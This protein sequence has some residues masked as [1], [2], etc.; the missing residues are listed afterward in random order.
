M[1]VAIVS[2][3]P[4][5]THGWGRYTRDLI[6]GLA[7]QPAAPQVI[8]ITARDAAPT[9]DLPVAEYHRVLPSLTPARRFSMLRLL[10]SIPAVSRL[11]AGCDVVHVIAEPY[12]L[13]VP[14]AR[15]VIMTAHGTY[16]AR[17]A[18]HRLVGVL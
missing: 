18:A 4:A 2:T 12:A 3:A 15:R 1:R 10:A 17:T 13:T 8:F 11:T 9:T 14:F 7:Q 16:T 6:T 5:D